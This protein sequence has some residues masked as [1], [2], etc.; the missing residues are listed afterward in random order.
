MTPSSAGH[1]L[2][3]TL[4]PIAVLTLVWGCNWPILKIGVA[5]LAPGSWVEMI[6]RIEL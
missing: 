5:E 1:P 3:R 2:A 4:A 6:E